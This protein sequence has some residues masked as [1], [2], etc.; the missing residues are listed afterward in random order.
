MLIG[1]L[2]PGNLSAKLRRQENG[3]KVGAVRIGRKHHSVFGSGVL[4]E[5][6]SALSAERIIVAGIFF[7]QPA[8]SDNLRYCLR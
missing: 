8:V 7:N 4:S 1:I 3:R 5:N 2:Q 6:H